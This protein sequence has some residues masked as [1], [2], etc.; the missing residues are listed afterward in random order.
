MRRHAVS[1]TIGTLLMC[2]GVAELWS[3]YQEAHH[4][5]RLDYCTVVS[6]EAETEN[7]CPV[8]K[9]FSNI[10]RSAE[11]LCAM[12]VNASGECNVRRRAPLPH[13][14]RCFVPH[15][16]VATH[17][18]ATVITPYR[19]RI[20]LLVASAPRDAQQTIDKLAWQRAQVGL[21]LSAAGALVAV[22][23]GTDIVHR[24]QRIAYKVL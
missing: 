9:V 12:L 15:N 8:Y 5:W 19:E 6:V 17:E 11:P 18:C 4:T 16:S 23:L 10:Y 13:D 22:A 14:V 24:I 3:A 7:S 21:M 20:A 2:A 1:A